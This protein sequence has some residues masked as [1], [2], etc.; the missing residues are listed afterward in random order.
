MS[1]VIPDGS[2]RVVYW[3]TPDGELIKASEPPGHEPGAILRPLVS[4]PKD[5]EKCWEWQGKILPNGYGAK[6]MNGRFVLAHRWVWALL[7]GKIP[8]G[9]VIDHV[10][11]NRRCV[12]PFHLRVVTQ[13]E[14]V[15]SGINTVLTAGDVQEARKLKADGWKVVD[16]ARKLDVANSTISCLLRGKSW[17][18]PKK[19]YGRNTRSAA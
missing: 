5:P 9:L 19:F 15:R 10:C 4:L 16:I 12:N 17:A 14:N 6:T 7:L 13:A 2:K 8:D 18:K 11:Q 3:E 1:V